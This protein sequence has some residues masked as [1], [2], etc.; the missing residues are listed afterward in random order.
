MCF[1]CSIYHDCAGDRHLRN[2]FVL[3]ADACN[4]KMLHNLNPNMA[5]WCVTGN[6]QQMDE[7]KKGLWK[8]LMERFSS[9][10]EE[11]PEKPTEK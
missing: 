1:I 3:H 8:T 6:M 7:E 11:S 4:D 2:A 5:S 10:P 9:K